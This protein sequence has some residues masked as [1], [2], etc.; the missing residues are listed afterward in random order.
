MTPLVLQPIKAGSTVSSKGTL[1][2]GSMKC[3]ET[4]DMTI[5]LSRLQSF[6][7]ESLGPSDLPC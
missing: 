3:S 5:Q 4:A 6:L 7:E 1:T 2:T